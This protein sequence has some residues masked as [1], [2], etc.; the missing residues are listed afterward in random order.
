MEHSRSAAGGRLHLRRVGDVAGL[1]RHT[2]RGGGGQPGAYLGADHAVEHRDRGAARGEQ[3]DDAAADKAA[4]AGYQEALVLDLHGGTSPERN[5]CLAPTVY[6][7]RARAEA[8]HAVPLA[9]APSP[10]G[11]GAVVAQAIKRPSHSRSQP[12]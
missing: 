10:A 5:A 1:Q 9:I 6:H 4:A 11:R 7:P 12:R 3:P 2:V 8:R